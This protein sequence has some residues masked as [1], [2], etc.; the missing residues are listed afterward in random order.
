MEIT[1]ETLEKNDKSFYFLGDTFGIKPYF[2]QRKV[3]LNTLINKKFSL[4]EIRPKLE[5]RINYTCWCSAHDETDLKKYNTKIRREF[6]YTYDAIT[7]RL[8][9]TFILL[10]HIFITDIAKILFLM[11]YEVAFG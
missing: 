7:K 8:H 10:N 4:L 11:Y 6:N 5:Y 9:N 1:M 3:S 2:I